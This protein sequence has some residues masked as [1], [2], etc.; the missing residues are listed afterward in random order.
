MRILTFMRGR[1][2]RLLLLLFVALPACEAM[3]RGKAEHIVLVVWDGMRPDFVNQEHAP[4][5]SALRRDGVFFA[6]NHAVYPSSTNVN[7]AAIATGN[8]PGHTGV[9]GNQE[10][11]AAI[12]A[13]QPFDTAEYPDLRQVDPALS[14]RYLSVPTIPEILHHAGQWTAVAGAKP[15]AQLFDRLRERKSEAEKQSGVVYRGK[16][17]P[18]Q[19]EAD[20]TKALGPF[21]PRHTFPNRAQDEWTTHALTEMLW[22]SAVPEFSLLWLS[23]PDL[24]EHETAPGAPTSLAAIKSSDDNLGQVIAALK[25]KDALP[26]TDIFVVSD[27]GFSTIDL[28]VDVAERLRAAGFDA[29]R[30]FAD[31]PPRGQ[32]LVVTLGGSVAL[33]VAGH[34]PEMIRRLVDFL[35]QSDFAGVIFTREARPGTFTFA[36]AMIETADAP[37]LLVACRWNDQP[38]EFKVRG[39]IASDIGHSAGHG[40]HATLSPFDIHNTLIASGPDFRHGWT[41]ETPSGN[42]DLAPTILYLLGLPQLKEMEGR[43]LTEALRNGKPA[44]AAES[45]ELSAQSERWRQNIRLTRV[46]RTTYIDEGNGQR[47]ANAPNEPR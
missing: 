10:F 41:D 23:E 9:I 15:V 16:V 12:D 8:Y 28:S 24:T 46:G 25:A 1:C 18:K 38:N 32:I 36:Q 42:I 19:I 33:Y 31:H 35:Q 3:T 44:P 22:K 17:F 45:R 37:D 2:F 7:G 13:H 26:T 11:R 47:V 21:P 27:H 43:V 4:N 20:V 39:A 14:A 29:V 6:N 34:D 30:A 5:L 40:T